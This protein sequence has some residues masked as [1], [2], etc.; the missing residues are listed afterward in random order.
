M[1]HFLSVLDTR[2]VEYEWNSNGTGVL[3]IPKG[4]YETPGKTR[5]MPLEYGKVTMKQLKAHEWSYLRSSSRRDQDSYM[6]YHCLLNSLT[7]DARSKVQTWREDY[8]V[9]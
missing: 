4:K 8:L 1:H 5:Y 6:M 7:K 9:R 2:A 3:W